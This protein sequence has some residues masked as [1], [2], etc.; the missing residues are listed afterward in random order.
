M[1]TPTTTTHPVEVFDDASGEIPLQFDGHLYELV[2]VVGADVKHIQY[3]WKRPVGVCKMGWALY[4]ITH[5][6]LGMSAKH[7]GVC[8]IWNTH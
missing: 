2:E 4:R 7:L 8:T 5:T 6:T 3:P 1:A